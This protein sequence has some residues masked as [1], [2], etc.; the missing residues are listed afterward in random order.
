MGAVFGVGLL[1]HL[2]SMSEEEQEETMMRFASKCYGPKVTFREVI[3]SRVGEW[4]RPETV[5]KAY[6]S[7]S[8]R[9]LKHEE[10]EP[11]FTFAKREHNSAPYSQ[12]SFL[13]GWQVFI[14]GSHYP[15]KPMELPLPN[16]ETMTLRIN[17]LNRGIAGLQ[18]INRKIKTYDDDFWQDE[19]F[20]CKEY[21][22]FHNGIK[23]V[24]KYCKQHHLIYVIGE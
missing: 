21:V 11:I 22:T 10:A 9:W 6:M 13:N 12:F 2:P 15:R 5:D 16:N 8:M 20:S 1:G 4:M 3:G 7:I 24:M 23:K 18:A 17:T 14:P 19:R